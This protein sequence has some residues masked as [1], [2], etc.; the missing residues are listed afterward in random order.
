M[1]CPSLPRTV[2]GGQ[3]QA[4]SPAGPQRLPVRRGYGLGGARFPEFTA[5]PRPGA[6]EGRCVFAG[7]PVLGEACLPSYPAGSKPRQRGASKLWG[8]GQLPSRRRAGVWGC[9]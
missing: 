9:S 5:T 7:A 3:R 2:G 8:E 1:G 4:R 6:P